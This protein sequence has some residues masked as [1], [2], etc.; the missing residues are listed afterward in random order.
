MIIDFHTHIFPEKIAKPTL[1]F[2]KSRCHTEPATNGMSNGLSKSSQDAGIHISV[3]L[4]VVT[5]PKQFD[6]INGFAQKLNEQDYRDSRII[7][8]GGIHPDSEDYKSQLN[9]IKDMG[10]LGVKLHPDYQGVFIDDIRY[11]HIIDYASK[12]DLIVSVHAGFDPGY[13]ECVHCTPQMARSVIREVQPK[14]LVLAHLGGFQQWDEV[15]EYLVG[16]DIYLDTAVIFPTI[17]DQQFLQIVKNHGADRIL[18]ATDS[19]WAGQKA[20]KNKI[21]NMPMT[22]KEKIAILGGNAAKLLNLA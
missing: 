1:D 19:P 12:L 20:F 8:F 3:A 17:R 11:K 13:P 22:E 10:F 21:Q 18:F 9:Q 16:E 6:S 14:K 2:L 15:E 7:S 5:N 4:P